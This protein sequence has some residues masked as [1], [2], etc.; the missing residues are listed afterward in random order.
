MN[1]KCLVLTNLSQHFTR[2]SSPRIGRDIIIRDSM[3][4]LSSEETVVTAGM[5]SLLIQ[6]PARGDY[7]ST[8]DKNLAAYYQELQAA[9]PR[10]A[11]LTVCVPQQETPL[12]IHG[13]R[14]RFPYIIEKE[15][16]LSKGTYEVVSRALNP[17]TRDLCV[18]KKLYVTKATKT[19]IKA[20]I[21]INQRISH[22]R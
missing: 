9:L 17:S 14:G 20:E 6:I 8:F 16:D 19:L 3:I 22:V 7:Q 2:L 15:G 1:S 10:L 11:G 12:V 18:V 13:K 21:E 5:V 4:I